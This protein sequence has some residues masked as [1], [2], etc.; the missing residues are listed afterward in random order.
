MKIALYQMNIAWLSIARNL[1]N[2]R[3]VA[4][5]IEADI[6][7]L[8][9]M[10]LTGFCMDTSLLDMDMDMDMETVLDSLR[11]ICSDHDI[12]IIGSLGVP[13][14]DKYYNR[15][16]VIN[17][18][19]IVHRYDKQYL[20][21]PADEDKS[22]AR[23]YDDP[24]VE[25]EG[26]RI[27]LQICYELRFPE[28]IRRYDDVDIWLY[29]ANWPKVRIHHWQKLLMAR[30]IE[31]QCYVIGCNR[32]GNDGNGWEYYGSSMVVDYNGDVDLNLGSE[33]RVAPF[34]I[35]V[36]EARKYRSKLD[37][38]KDKKLIR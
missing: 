22:Y 28:A 35:D 5:Q 26:V 29:V 9:E 34:M 27:G 1:E 31:N 13:D 15:M 14:E 36:S 7:L 24:I 12:T 38:Q 21:S 8:P 2:I 30:A 16:Y 37:F 17:K 19:G 11:T 20:F 23:K 18:G 4:S 10:F 33:E 6:L 32:T 25:L 3:T